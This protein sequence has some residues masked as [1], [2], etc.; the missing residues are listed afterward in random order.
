MILYFHEKKITKK[1]SSIQ[2]YLLGEIAQHMPDEQNDQSF[3][4]NDFVQFHEKNIYLRM[5]NPKLL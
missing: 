5:Y 3:Q 1:K 2:N 4:N